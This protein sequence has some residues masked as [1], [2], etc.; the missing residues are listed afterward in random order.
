[1]EM[2]NSYVTA[3][4]DGESYYSAPNVQKVNYPD[5]EITQSSDKE[6]ETL[7]YG[8]ETEYV[9]KIKIILT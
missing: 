5:F 3:S 9:F 1:M 2:V 8:E 7:K 6:G 4:Y